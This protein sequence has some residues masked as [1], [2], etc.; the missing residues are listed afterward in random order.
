MKGRRSWPARRATGLPKLDR[1]RVVDSTLEV[2]AQGIG[3]A[4]NA[5]FPWMSIESMLEECPSIKI[6]QRDLFNSAASD[7]SSTLLLVIDKSEELGVSPSEF[8]K[9]KDF[10]NAVAHKRGS[11]R[12]R[13]VALD[14][15]RVQEEMLRVA[16]VLSA[17]SQT[18]LESQVKRS[19]V[20]YLE[21]HPRRGTM[22]MRLRSMT[23]TCTV[24]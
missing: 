24:W 14:A 10:R 11:A 21:V 22:M 7:H 19:L 9:L 13:Q 20:Y 15:S 18:S 4:I 5:R 1:L 6:H 17:L 2:L 23:P 12:A 8:H 3:N 16:S